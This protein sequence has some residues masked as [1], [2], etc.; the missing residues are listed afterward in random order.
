M[1]AWSSLALLLACSC[2]DAG[3]QAADAGDSDAGDDAIPYESGAPSESDALSDDAGADSSVAACTDL[4]VK[5]ARAWDD[6][7]YVGRCPFDCAGGTASAYACSLAPEAGTPTYPSAFNVNVDAV[8]VVAL[9]AG[10]YPWDASA[11][12]SC[13]ALTC[14]RW[15]TG[16][17]VEGGSAWPG[18]PCADGGAATLAWVCP[19][20]PGVVPRPAGCF[21]AGDM[22][23]IGG[24]GTG[25][26]TDSVW[27]CPSESA[28]LDGGSGDAGGDGAAE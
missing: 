7:V 13:A 27:C 24:T 23:T 1:R 26:S 10:A 21:A 15:A 17:H 14:T 22:Q 4:N 25:V 5:G 28:V 9:L 19:P 8:D 3:T 12:E 6:C 2:S 11:Y 16:D 18:D 20:S